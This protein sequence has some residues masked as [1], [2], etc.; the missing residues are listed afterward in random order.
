MP[1]MIFVTT[2]DVLLC[3]AR[4]PQGLSV[5]RTHHYISI[6]FLVR[7]RSSIT[8]ASTLGSTDPQGRVERSTQHVGRVSYIL[9]ELNIPAVINWQRIIIATATT[10]RR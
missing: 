4:F 5:H 1:G 8:F 6:Q 9:T 10:T 2:G 7:E 3:G